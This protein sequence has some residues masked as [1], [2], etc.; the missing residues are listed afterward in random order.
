MKQIKM[1][2]VNLTIFL[3]SSLIAQGNGF[4][5]ERI[6]FVVS[7]SST[8][9]TNVVELVQKKLQNYTNRDYLYSTFEAKSFTEINQ[10]FESDLIVTVGTIAAEAA[11]KKNLNA[12]VLMVLL[13]DSAFSVLATQ[14][15]GSVV[16]AHESR[17]SLITLDQPFSRSIKLS[18]L[19]IPGVKT[20]GIMTGPASSKKNEV[21]YNQAAA[22]GIA[23]KIVTIK[24]ADN[25]VHKL[26]PIIEASDVFIPLPDNRLINIAT[27]KWI[28]QLSFRDKV[29]VIGYS[30][31]YLDAG[32]LAAIYSSI[33]NVA[34]QTAQFIWKFKPDSH[35]HS[36]EPADFSIEFNR[37]VAA[38]LN[39][40]LESEYFYRHQL[41][42]K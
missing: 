14:Y 30:K 39:I 28:L 23:S 24:L 6:T 1:V 7:K 4:S 3:S 12:P 22:E 16:E 41:K 38:N 5:G 35:G 34:Q 40:R 15:Y 33:E 26:E 17:V 13:T 36:Y 27:A 11:M 37:S 18:K 21:I 25:P 2:I 9:Y 32:A 19:L 29:P 31:T 42:V 20:V 8:T 10:D